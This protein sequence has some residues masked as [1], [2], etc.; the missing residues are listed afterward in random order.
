MIQIRRS[1]E[2]G[3]FDEGWLQT[4]HTF[5]F[6]EYY[7]AKHMGFR[8][9]RVINE[10]H[11]QP[12]Q[13]FETH[14]HR[15]MEILTYV[16]EGALEHKDSMGNGSIINAGDVQRM[17]AGTGVTHSESNP[18]PT[19]AVHL[20]QIWILPEKKGLKP[21]YQQNY[22]S[23]EQKKNRLCC[24][25]SREGEDGSLLIHQDVKIFSSL[26]SAGTLLDDSIKDNH[27]VWVQ[28]AKGNVLLNNQSLH[29][30]D[31]ASL[32]GEKEIEILSKETSDLL[33]FDFS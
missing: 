4:F 9:L 8:A 23:E 5:S 16:L 24:I 13:G 18:S 6:G 15:D 30:G 10:D 17:S 19:T 22:F 21:S 31:G 7:D 25:A 29:A 14:G 33:L 20:L 3:F 12:G 28:V 1:K 2:R 27:H 32:S 26:L 11:V